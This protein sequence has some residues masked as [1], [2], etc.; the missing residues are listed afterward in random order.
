MKWSNYNEKVKWHKWFAWYPVIVGDN[1]VWL[2]TV[3]RR[4][5][6]RS[7]WEYR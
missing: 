3:E 1:E 2:E 7:K 6:G 4:F 5:I